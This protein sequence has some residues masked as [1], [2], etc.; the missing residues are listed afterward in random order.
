MMVSGVNQPLARWSVNYTGASLNRLGTQ[1]NAPTLTLAGLRHVDAI[2]GGGPPAPFARR[3]S[4]LRGAVRLQ[5]PS[6]LLIK[7]RQLIKKRQ[8][9][10]KLPQRV[11]HCAYDLSD[12][13]RNAY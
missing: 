9:L 5:T 3:S 11:L 7:R 1:T 13:L 6:H 10:I 8:Q 2:H 4:W 12:W